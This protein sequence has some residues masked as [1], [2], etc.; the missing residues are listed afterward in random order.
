MAVAAGVLTLA[1][2]R[3]GGARASRTMGEISMPRVAGVRALRC[4]SHRSPST[5]VLIFAPLP[6]RISAP[7]TTH[8]KLYI[9]ATA[10]FG[11][12]FE[13]NPANG[14]DYLVQGFPIGP[15]SRALRHF[16]D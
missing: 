5:K 11:S 4:S 14:L 16:D 2:T 8:A 10:C 6:L 15:V 12:G 3:W 13:S 7:A 1:P 9:V